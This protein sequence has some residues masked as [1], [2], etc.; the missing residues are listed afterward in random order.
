VAVPQQV[1]RDDQVLVQPR[2]SGGGALLGAVIGGALGNSLGSGAGRAAATGL[3]VIAGAAIGDNTEAVNNPP[4]AT[5]VRNCQTVMR[6]ENRV[7]GYNVVYEYN[8]HTY[9]SRMAQDPGAQIALNV[10]PAAGAVSDAQ[11]SGLP[12]VYQVPQSAVYGP[13]VGYAPPVVYAPALGYGPYPAYG[14]YGGNYGGYYGGP[15]FVFSAN[16][17]H[18]G[19]GGHGHH[20]H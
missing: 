18:G 8:G 11:T 3:G 10:A 1:C 19:Y 9:N 5:T 20:G 4:A 16:F 14:Y 2:T 6:Y 15:A 7:V 13:S 12:P 17:G